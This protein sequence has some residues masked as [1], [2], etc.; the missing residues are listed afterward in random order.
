MIDDR[1]LV[2]VPDAAGSLVDEFPEVASEDL[3]LPDCVLGEGLQ[4]LPVGESL[5]G[6]DRLGDGVL[7]DLEDQCGGP[8]EESTMS[9]SSEVE[10]EGFEDLLP[11][12]PDECS[13][14]HGASPVAMPGWI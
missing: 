3:G 9:G 6:G 14:P 1:D 13:P 11:E 5:D 8:L 2:A 4:S 7:L 10:G 12:E